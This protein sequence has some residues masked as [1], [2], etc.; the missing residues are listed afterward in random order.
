MLIVNGIRNSYESRASAY[1]Y[2]QFFLGCELHTQFEVISEVVSALGIE[3]VGGKI[4][5][6]CY[7]DWF[8]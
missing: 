6:N 3:T 4:T 7:R 8:P 1:I 5:W 2:V